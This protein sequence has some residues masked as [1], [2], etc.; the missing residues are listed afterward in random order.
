MS[1]NLPFKNI[2]AVGGATV[3]S[4]FPSANI[5]AIG[6]PNQH[7][8]TFSAATRLP[9]TA[10]ET[11]FRGEQELSLDRI[12]SSVRAIKRDENTRKLFEKFAS[13]WA[14]DTQNLSDPQ[15]TLLHPSYQRILAM[16][17]S[18]LPYIFDDF[19]AGQGAK[20]LP[21]LDAIT[22][23]FVNPVLPEHEDDAELMCQDWISWGIKYGCITN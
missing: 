8:E 1:S 5:F 18:V 23:G 19:V 17:T 20:W 7:G 22:L 6:F 2:S 13:E 21:A 11:V 12:A 16:G 10:P 15:I 14:S 3:L 4:L 9:K